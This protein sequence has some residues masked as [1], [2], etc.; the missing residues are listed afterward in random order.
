MWYRNAFVCS[1]RLVA[2]V[3]VASATLLFGPLRATAQSVL[4]LHT[5]RAGDTD[6][7]G[8]DATLTLGSDGNFYGISGLGGAYGLGCVYKITPVGAVSIVHSFNGNDGYGSNVPLVQASDTSLWGVAQRGPTSGGLLFRVTLA[9][10]F[11]LVHAFT[12]AEGSTPTGICLARDGNFYCTLNFANQ[13]QGSIVKVSATGAAQLLHAFRGAPDGGR[14]QGA[15][16]QASDGS[17]YGMAST[18]G[19]NSVGA[20][21]KIDTSLN[22]TVFYSF[23]RA[24]PGSQVGLTYGPG[25][26]LSG[27]SRGGEELFTMPIGGSFTVLHT[28]TAAEG[29]IVHS[30]LLVNGTSLVGTAEGSS[31]GGGQLFSVTTS[32]VFSLISSFAASAGVF[33]FAGVTLGADGSY[34]GVTALGGTDAD[35]LFWTARNGGPVVAITPFGNGNAEGYPP[36]AGLL[37]AG[38]ASFYASMLQGGVAGYGSVDSIDHSGA[39]TVVQSL[40]PGDGANP[41]Y[42][43]FRAQDGSVYG[44]T[45][46][47]TST[48][49]PVVYRISPAGV[50]SVLY[51]FP[52]GNQLTS[53]VILASDG[54]LYG[55]GSIV[56]GAGST[57]SALYRLTT[58]GVLSVVHTFN[59]GD[60]T[61]YEPSGQVL[62]ASDHNLYGSTY[63]GGLDNLG[64]VYRITLAGAITTVHSFDGTDGAYPSGV[65]A[66]N[67]GSISGACTT[68]GANL[69]GVLFQTTI[70]NSPQFSVLH[71]FSAFEGSPLGYAVSASDGALYGVTQNGGANSVGA[72][73][74]CDLSGDFR[75]LR[76]FSLFVDG[77]SP[78]GPLSELGGDL[79]GLTQSGGSPAVAGASGTMFRINL[80]LHDHD[81]TGDAHPDILF[82]NTVTGDVVYWAMN[83]LV[84]TGSGVITSSLDPSWQLVCSYD[85][86]LSGHP[87]LIFHNT[88]TGAVVYWL[89]NGTTITGSGTLTPGVGL[90]W[91]P[92]TIADM[93]G[94]GNPYL[95]WQNAST[96]SVVYWHLNGTKVTNTG[97]LFP[98]LPT[99]LRLVG[100]ADLNGD[101]YPDLVFQ[102]TSTGDVTCLFMQNLS[103]LA[104]GYLATGLDA[105]WS[106]CGLA[107]FNGDYHPDL[108][109]HN[110]VTGAMVYWLLSGTE[111]IGSGEIATLSTQ[112]APIER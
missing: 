48:L 2:C 46:A 83:G 106:A 34:N 50:Y 51:T 1:K 109:W 47:S 85:L 98:S 28:L 58:A 36:A 82:Q 35:G 74:R 22:E 63:L 59:P 87:D 70:G 42:P 5:F 65:V 88:K 41:S 30:P 44:V 26:A 79:Y 99:S 38:G 27:A 12:P 101:G 80:N 53:G 14:P 90:A 69:N 55:C 17:L 61:G 107:D 94:N 11:S 29:S 32:G 78:V 49:F 73:Y 15:P 96:G 95:L 31:T 10:S 3:G 75:L 13:A 93:D 57:V 56:V 60:L 67:S 18:G 92:I 21:Y 43:L 7:S 89:M 37:S 54:N 45:Q 9:G 52:A 104:S 25:N 103:V 4:T 97:T 81:V 24:H 62:Q 66:I 84:K 91:N 112:W 64:V 39:V 72:V 71:N 6:P 19:A 20:I 76:S 23:T 68:G 102:N 108:L 110:T 33:P 40:L 111:T 105:D 16:V 100:A 86:T 77:G 8:T